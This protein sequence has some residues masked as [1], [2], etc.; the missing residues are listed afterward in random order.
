M[1]DDQYDALAK[2]L[3][4]L[5]GRFGANVFSDR[6][7]VVSVL[8]DRVPEARRDI[9]VIGSCID[10]GIFD[11][12]ASTRPD[13]VVFEIDRLA[14]R[15]EGNLGIRKDIALPIV[16]A[17]AHGLGRGPLPSA[18]GGP[19]PV[20]G[21][22][23]TS[24][25]DPGDGWVG[26]SEP[27]QRPQGV[28]QPGTQQ[29][30]W[31]NSPSNYPPGPP[32]QG[33]YAQPGYAPSQGTYGQPPQPGYMPSGSQAPT[34]TYVPA[35]SGG[36]TAAS[37]SKRNAIILAAVGGG[38]LL[39]IAVA[40]AIVFG[41]GD[42]KPQPPIVDKPVVDKPKPPVD[43]PVVDKPKP[44]VD[45]PVVDKPVVDKP[46]PPIDKPPPTGTV[47]EPEP[48]DLPPGKT[49]QPK[50]PTTQ[51]PPPTGGSRAFGDET[52]DFGVQIQS[53]LRSDVG[54]PT[55]NAIPVGKIIS[56]VLLEEE[57]RKGTQFL[58]VDVLEGQHPQTIVKARYIAYG[59]R[60]GSFTDQV[61]SALV[62]ELNQL[63]NGRKDFPIV[64]FCQGVRCWES[65]NA[66]LRA[67][68]AGYRNVY[69]YRGG[70]QAWQEAGFPMTATP[71]SR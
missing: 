61:Q 58:L 49:T 45:K 59:G 10:D 5:P 36:A 55:P 43:K 19:A 71:A 30:S 44:P 33:N 53:T 9:R 68:N 21:M 24:G 31:V 52:R 48:A 46:K 20:G 11:A 69:W 23:P 17:C 42:P 39:I 14:A 64:F 67:W 56:T 70:L 50:P 4:E 29:G 12:L 37:T 1:A 32:S 3:A 13:Q 27:V 41:G 28:S 7:R 54:S 8:S 57:I 65:Y 15:I 51:P 25:A 16:R 38:V 34:G 62:S 40:A 22:P 66:V 18:Y 60:G 6:R 26:V 2:V 63:T 35:G 47:T